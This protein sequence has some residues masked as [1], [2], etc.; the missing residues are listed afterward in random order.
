[1]TL[2]Y[3]MLYTEEHTVKIHEEHEQ[4]FV[5]SYFGCIHVKINQSSTVTLNNSNTAE[6]C[7]RYMKIHYSCRYLVVSTKFYD[8]H[9]VMFS[10]MYK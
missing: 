4:R 3:V 5:F 2:C 8:L 10:K 1:M 6:C 9:S 7:V